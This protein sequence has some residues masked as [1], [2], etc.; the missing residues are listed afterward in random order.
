MILRLRSRDG[1]E[2]VDV[3]EDATVDDLKNAVEES[4]GV[5]REDQTISAE[6]KLLTAKEGEAVKCLDQKSKRL[7]SYG[8]GH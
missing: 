3:S 8:I 5:K 2:R 7:E 4:L 6:A 1:L